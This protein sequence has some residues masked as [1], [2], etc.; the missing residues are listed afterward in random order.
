MRGGLGDVFD[1]IIVGAGSAGCVLAN[2]LSAD[3]ARRVLLL[4]AGPRD[5][6]PWIHVP[7][8]Y[9][10]LVYHPVFS[11][12]FA[13]GP[14]P[15]LDNRVMTWPGGRVLGGSSAINGMVYIRGQAQD[16]DMWRQSADAEG[17]AAGCPGWGWSDV[18]PYFRRAEDQARGEDAW[19]GIG[20]PLWVSDITEHHPLSDAFV[21][22]AMQWGLPRNDD[23]NGAT[24]EGVGT[25]QLT[26][27]R[28]RRSSVAAT[29]LRAARGRAN[30]TVLTD[31]RV[32]GV[33]LDGRRATGVRVYHAGSERKVSGGE[34]IVAAGAIRSPHLLML[35]GIGPADALHEVGVTVRHDLPGVGQ[36]LQ[37]HLQVKLAYRVE[38]VETI[39]EIRRSPLRMAREGLRFLLAAKGPLANSAFMSGGFVRS[40]PALERPDVQLHFQPLSGSSPGVFHEFPGCTLTVS[41]M[42]P[43]SR[44]AVW[45]RSPDPALAPAMQANYLVNE[46]DRRVVVTALRLGREIMRQSALR[47]FRPMEVVPGAAAEDD[48]ALLA[49]ARATGFTQFHQVGSCRM[50]TDDGAVVDAGLRVRGLEGLR[51][52]DASVMPTLVSGN[53][54]AAVV[55]IGEKAADLIIGRPAA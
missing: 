43:A 21:A 52:A 34:T 41:Q 51:V 49:H 1:V 40:D 3:P 13:A 47:G 55:M 38:G 48:A 50:G 45:L 35:S 23:F 25:Y 7:G 16:F 29:Y 12:N 36:N 28:R 14:E 20:G 8:G 44:G 32:T 15:G 22:A 19:H 27:R 17:G 5:R 37:D 11:W 30:L 46:H 26:A 9:Y 42:H 54:N 53:T 10:R 2:R 33:L 24:Q 6:N 4:E 18:L 31:A 39:N